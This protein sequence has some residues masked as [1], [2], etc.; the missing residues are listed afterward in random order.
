MIDDEYFSRLYENRKKIADVLDNPAARGLKNLLTG[1]YAETAHFI[2][3]LLQ[4]ADDVNA[5][6]TK[7]ILDKKGLIFI[8]NGSIPFS[9][10]NPDS[11]DYDK[12][13]GK[14]GHINAITSIGNSAKTIA[15]GFR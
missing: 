9:I 2:Y 8:H 10:S 13:K 6:K 1:M 3:E 5:S 14:F 12:E 4:N 7:F 11:E 15:S